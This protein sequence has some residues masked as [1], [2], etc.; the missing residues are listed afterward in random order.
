METEILDLLTP[1]ARRK[2][3]KDEA[4]Y[5]EW[6]RLSAIPGARATRVRQILMDKFE[7]GS[8]ATVINICRR[9]EQRLQQT[10]QNENKL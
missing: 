10:P 2:L 8:I 9:V 4:V 5:K 7:I 1:T 3:E 6:K